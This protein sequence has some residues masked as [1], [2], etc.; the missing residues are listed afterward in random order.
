M[1]KIGKRGKGRGKREKGRL[2]GK[3]QQ[4]I[5]YMLKPRVLRKLFCIAE[6]RL[7]YSEGSFT[8]KRRLLLHDGSSAC[9]ANLGVSCL[10][11]G[12][13]LRCGGSLPPLNQV[14]FKSGNWINE[15]SNLQILPK[16]NRN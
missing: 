16:K 7:V 14:F 5:Y 6:A 2:K 1:K 4:K 13:S 11:S 8:V 10:H 3:I 15:K 12:G 9:L